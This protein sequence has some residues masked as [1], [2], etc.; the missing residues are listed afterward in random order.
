MYYILYVYSYLTQK[1]YYQEVA[2][3]GYFTLFYYN[4][5]SFYM[6]E[7]RPLSLL[8]IFLPPNSKDICSAGLF[9]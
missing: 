2:K 3:K 7:C 8:C 5:P 6:L 4:T 9:C 1:F